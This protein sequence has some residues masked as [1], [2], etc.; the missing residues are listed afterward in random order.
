M[1]TLG[2]YGSRN[3]PWQQLALLEFVSNLKECLLNHSLTFSWNAQLWNIHSISIN[4]KAQHN[5]SPLKL[6]GFVPPADVG[7]TTGQ[8]RKEASNRM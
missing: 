1:A 2:T 3:I 8:A 7:G 4:T 6:F 5:R